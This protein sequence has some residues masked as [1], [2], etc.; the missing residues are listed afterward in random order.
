MS[1][2]GKLPNAF[3]IGIAT[4]LPCH[5]RRVMSQVIANASGARAI[6]RFWSSAN[7]GL[8]SLTSTVIIFVMSIAFIHASSEDANGFAGSLRRRRC[9]VSL[10]GVAGYSFESRRRDSSVG[11]HSHNGVRLTVTISTGYHSLRFGE[12]GSGSIGGEWML[13]AELM[14]LCKG[15][16]ANKTPHGSFVR[17]RQSIEDDCSGPKSA[18]R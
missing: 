14:A 18:E 6:S 4:D 8:T 10:H 1:R 3:W 5:R 9:G 2:V 15:R 7:I 12:P 16:E 11:N 13:I 17:P